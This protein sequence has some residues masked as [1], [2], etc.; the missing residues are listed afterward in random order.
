LWRDLGRAR[1]AWGQ[2]RAALRV[3]R[4]VPGMGPVASWDA[5]G[6][7]RMLSQV[8]DGDAVVTPLLDPANAA[9]RLTAETYLDQAGNAQRTAAALNVHRQTLYY[10]LSRIEALTGLDLDSGTDRLLLH[11]ALK[12]A[13]LEG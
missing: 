1:D 9:L 8:T 10:R 11:M 7:Y 6:P 13:H 5:L 2:A 4:G 12:V 3:A